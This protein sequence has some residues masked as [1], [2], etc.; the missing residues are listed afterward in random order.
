MNGSLNKR[1][2]RLTK[3]L[4][5]IFVDEFDEEDEDPSFIEALGLDPTIYKSHNRAGAMRYD[6]IAALN[7]TA[8]ADWENYASEEHHYDERNEEEA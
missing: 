3:A 1:L 6:H 7:A 4:K 5:C 2:E 8:A